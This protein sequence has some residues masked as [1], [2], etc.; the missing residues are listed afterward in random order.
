VLWHITFKTGLYDTGINLHL[1]DSNAGKFISDLNQKAHSNPFYNAVQLVAGGAAAFSGGYVRTAACFVA[2]TLVATVDGFK[3][4]EDIKTGDIVLSADENNLERGCKPVLETYIRK[5]DKLVHLK[6]NGEEIIST[7][8]HPY[9]VK[10]KGF[11][12]AVML[13]IGAELVNNNGDVLIVD[14]I[15]RES[16]HNEK[17]E[18]FNFQVEDY[19]TYYV[20]ETCVLVHNATYPK[21]SLDTLENTENFTEQSLKHIFE[22]E[23]N[24]RGK[25]VGFHYEGIENSAGSVVPGTKTT[26]GANGVYKGQVSVNGIPKTANGGYST[27]FPEEM[28][29]QQ[30][31]DCINEA[32]GN[33]TL[34]TP[35]PAPGMNSTYQG[36]TA[37]GIDVTMYIN[38]FGKIVSAFPG[39]N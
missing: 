32:Y 14:S 16:L 5:V 23:V 28:S 35:A 12:Q 13:W 17:C 9:Y 8:D 7:E 26:P 15:Y 29:P 3:A 34:V 6:I 38:D 2:G 11:V 20:G 18:V 25:A 19:H 30:V 36:V 31:V 1:I 39:G 33:K 24:S 22:G 21:A 10:G 27:L 4:I 37:G